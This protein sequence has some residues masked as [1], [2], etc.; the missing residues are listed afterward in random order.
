MTSISF[1]HN[2]YRSMKKVCSD[3]WHRYLGDYYSNPAHRYLT[4]LSFT[5]LTGLCTF[6]ALEIYRAICPHI[7]TPLSFLGMYAWATALNFGLCVYVIDEWLSRIWKGWGNF[8]HRTVGKVWLIW[9]FAFIMAFAIERTIIY[10][11]TVLYFPRMTSLYNT[12]PEARPTHLESFFYCFTF[13]SAIV[14]L[15]IQIAVK[16]QRTV[17]AE[18]SRINDLLEQREKEWMSRYQTNELTP[19]MPPSDPQRRETPRTPLFSIPTNHEVA[20]INPD[21]ISHITV[22]DH[23]CRIFIKQREGVKDYFVKIALKE[24]L[25]QLSGDRFVQIH[26]SHVIN[27]AHIS[28][29]QKEARSYQLILGHDEH[30]LPISRYR[31]SHIL[32]RLQEFLSST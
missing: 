29:L 12:H 19:P 32:P 21:E 15:L 17:E 6:G 13:W 28:R 18:R 25:S 26:R 5:L 14:F 2:G 30:A 16:R 27:L 3:Y 1:P 9:F 22:E 8:G 20:K 4:Y 11:T 24:I 23:Y 7:K 31:L 10:Q